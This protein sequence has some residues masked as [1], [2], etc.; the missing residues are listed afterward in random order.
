MTI[1]GI[2]KLRTKGIIYFKIKIILKVERRAYMISIVLVD[3]QTLLRDGME[4]MINLQEDMQVVG[5]ASNGIQVLELLTTIQPD[6]VL[7]DIQMSEMDG[8]ECTR[9]VKERFPGIKV[10]I[11]T[12]FAENDYIIDSFSL[13][14]NG[15]LLKDLPGEQM[16]QSIRDAY[17]GNMLLPSVIASK[18]VNLLPRREGVGVGA[19]AARLQAE[20]LKK[21]G[22]F[23]TQ[24]EK[25]IAE[26]FVQKKS[27]R[28]IAKEL[29]MS[30]GTV[31][32]YISGIYNKMGSNDR[33]YV[34]SVLER[35]IL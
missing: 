29:F 9:R 15:F 24:R 5:V 10:L 28:Q 33:E 31:R 1:T 32:N 21:E 7:M 17:H 8:I 13:G 16:I 12:T 19:G 6:I 3:D 14:V 22:I 4:T 26:L 34:I 11:L 20:K 35:L 27:N 2:E 23:L 25:E 18:I 30:E